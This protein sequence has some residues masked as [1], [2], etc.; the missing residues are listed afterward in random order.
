MNNFIRFLALVF[1]TTS[2][3]A[4]DSA[5]SSNKDNSS[6][7]SKKTSN[8]KSENSSTQYDKLP[9]NFDPDKREHIFAG[10]DGVNNYAIILDSATD[11]EDENH[12]RKTTYNISNK[13]IATIEE[14]E[15]SLDVE[16]VKELLKSE[17]DEGKS[18]YEKNK[19]QFEGFLQEAEARL[20]QAIAANES[21]GEIQKLEQ[22]VALLK[23]MLAGY[24]ETQIIE[25]FIASNKKA[26]KL[27]PLKAG[28]ATI[29]LTTVVKFKNQNGEE[30]QQTENTNL[31]L[32][33]EDYRSQSHDYYELGHSR[34]NI[35]A[36]GNQQACVVCHAD[37]EDGKGQVHPDAI[38]HAAAETKYMPAKAMAQ[39]IKEGVYFDRVAKV[40]HNWEFASDAEEKGVVAYLRSLA[41]QKIISYVKR[42]Y[43]AQKKRGA[44]FG[45][46]PGGAQVPTNPRPVGL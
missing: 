14:V 26:F 25:G 4:C 21:A 12:S 10:F 32:T 11:Y 38:D 7:Y 37:S 13:D 30:E 20:S 27:T 2:V 29:K 46:I 9:N 35:G 31:I 22:Q 6:G 34:Y 24:D 17:L 5:P 3:V 19:P 15:I 1:V 8:N 45:D 28:K 42:R 39:W 36:S 18:R 41:E 40:K 16:T 44:D 43:E 23:K 33:V